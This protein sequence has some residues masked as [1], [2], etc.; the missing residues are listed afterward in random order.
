MIGADQLQ[1]V[2][3]F[4]NAQAFAEQI[5]LTPGSRTYCWL[6]G[7][8]I[9]GDIIEALVT[10]QLVEMD[11]ICISTLGMS[12]ENIDSLKN[13]LVM[14]PDCK[15]YM[16]ISAYFYSHYRNDL[17]PYLYGE[18]DIG[19]RTQISFSNCHGKIITIHTKHGHN[20]TIHGSA[21]LRSC[22]CI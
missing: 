4:E 5:D 14:L 6:S 19:D 8:F 16:M 12:M 11:E 2:V 9:F 21:N 22:N 10:E 18:L 13:V 3:A 20:I 17:I 7:N 1:K 15:L